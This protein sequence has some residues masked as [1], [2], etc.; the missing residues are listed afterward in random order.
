MLPKIK[1]KRYNTRSTD[2]FENFPRP[3]EKYYKSFFPHFTRSWN[4]LDKEIRE[5]RDH[6]DFKKQIKIRLEPPRH[7]HYKYGDKYANNFINFFFQYEKYDTF[8]SFQW[9]MRTNA[10]FWPSLT[11]PANPVKFFWSKMACTCVPHIVLHVSCRTRTSGGY[12]RPSEVRF[13]AKIPLSSH[14]FY[15]VKTQK[16]HFLK[17]P[18]WADF[19][20]LESNCRHIFLHKN[21]K[22]YHSGFFFSWYIFSSHVITWSPLWGRLPPDQ[23]TRMWWA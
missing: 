5:D 4:N 3:N 8:G 10:L 15:N 16:T 7:P 21:Q 2:E 17:I 18:E 9:E 1:D 14:W 11:P 19:D 13:R 22:I 6:H 12:F 20:L 23:K